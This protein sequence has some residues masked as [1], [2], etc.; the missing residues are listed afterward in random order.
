MLFYR[1]FSSVGTGV[2]LNRCT[3]FFLKRLFIYELCP[4]ARSEKFLI[5]IAELYLWTIW[6][7]VV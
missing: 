7:S 4:M 3:H 6:L 2:T 5:L 1:V